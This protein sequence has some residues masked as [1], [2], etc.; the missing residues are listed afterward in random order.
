MDALPEK[1]INDYAYDATKA[2]LVL[3]PEVGRSLSVIF[4]T[5]FSSPLDK[6]KEK[7]LKQL[8]QTVDELCDKVNGITLETLANN[9]EFISFYIQASNR[10]LSK[11]IA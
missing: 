11:I 7:W 9:P 4:E 10:H 2:A 5:V 1:N 8:A 3:I 6:R